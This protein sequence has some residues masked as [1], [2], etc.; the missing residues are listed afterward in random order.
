[1]EVGAGGTSLTVTF[2][3]SGSQKEAGLVANKK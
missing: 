1:M 3:K 2:T